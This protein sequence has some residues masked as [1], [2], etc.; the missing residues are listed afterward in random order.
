MGMAE[1][2]NLIVLRIHLPG[3]RE[4]IP[5]SEVERLSLP[6]E[7]QDVSGEPVMVDKADSDKDDDK[8]N[9]I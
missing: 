1:N 2:P 9:A 6:T 4:D 7:L 8:G 5:P 3:N